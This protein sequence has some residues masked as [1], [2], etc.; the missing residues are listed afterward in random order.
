[1]RAEAARR[2]G[3]LITVGGN[4]E[5]IEEVEAVDTSPDPFDQWPTS[6][7]VQRFAGQTYGTE[8]SRDDSQHATRSHA[9]PGEEDTEGDAVLGRAKHAGTTRRGNERS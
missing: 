1:M 7:W 2:V 8:A 6:Q 3:D 9:L 4:Y 5:L